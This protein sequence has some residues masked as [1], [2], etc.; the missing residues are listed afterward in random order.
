MARPLSWTWSRYCRPGDL[1]GAGI[2]N[3][4]ASAPDASPSEG[5]NAGSIYV[6]FGKKKNWPATPFNLGNL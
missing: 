3:V 4:I 2:A 6:Y 5:A 1:N